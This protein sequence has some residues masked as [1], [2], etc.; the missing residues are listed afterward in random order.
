M[1]LLMDLQACQSE[2]SA[3]RGVGRYAEGLATHIAR[4]I[5]G[6]D[7]RLC[8]NQAYDD[9]LKRALDVFDLLLPRQNS[10]A[11]SY[12]NV[13]PEN[14]GSRQPD[15]RVAEALVR[16]HWMTLQP[17]VLHIAHVFEGFQGQA[18]MPQPLPKAPGVIRSTTL[19]DLIPLR[20]PDRYL[21]DAPYKAW[22]R[23]RMDAL[24]ECEQILAISASTR[25]DAIELAGIDAG[26]ITTIW[27]GVDPVFRTQRIGEQDAEA[28]R[29]RY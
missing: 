4:Q 28:I 15:R 6:D 17:D 14:G 16:R 21:A 13:V 12:P 7:L 27:G 10:S 23:R 2:V 8:F 9:Q 1:R 18:V 3:A 19:Y 25:A 5:G 11:Y 24:R 29:A 22:Y 26:R 20:F